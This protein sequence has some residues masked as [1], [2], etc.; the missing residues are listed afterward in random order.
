MKFIALFMAIIFIVLNK[1]IA[2]I[3]FN[4]QIIFNKTIYMK[5]F[6]E[7]H[8][9][10]EAMRILKTD[11][12]PFFVFYR[13]IIYVGGVATLVVSILLWLKILY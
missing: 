5:E 4:L 13:I 3:F 1:P 12:N 10:D 8:G 6:I 7:R 11:S 9:E 2:R